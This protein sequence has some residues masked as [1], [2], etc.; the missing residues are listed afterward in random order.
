MPQSHVRNYIHLIF[1]TKHRV[2]VIHESIQAE[3]FRYIAGICNNHDCFPVKIGGFTN[4]VHALFLLSK[5]I[6]LVKI[7]EEIKAHSSRW[8]K[9]KAESYSNF[10]WQNGYGAFSVNPAQID[11]AT[12]Y[13]ENQ[14][15]H[16]QQMTFE[17]EYRSF[18]KKYGVAY[19]EKYVWD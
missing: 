2:H 16:H 14:K 18:L 12:A 15:M 13:I 17:E 3:L 4:H 19:E 6:A 10:Y 1:S 11:T 9:T 5:K 7:V 8:I